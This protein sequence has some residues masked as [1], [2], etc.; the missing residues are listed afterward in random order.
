[1][2]DEM[3]DLDRWLRAN[4]DAGKRRLLTGGHTAFFA[5]RGLLTAE[6]RADIASVLKLAQM[7]EDVS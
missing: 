5:K 6:D 1:M 4:D 2:S 3:A 7:T